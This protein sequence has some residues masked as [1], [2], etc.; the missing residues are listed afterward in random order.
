VALSSSISNTRMPVPFLA[1]SGSGRHA[2]AA[3]LDNALGQTESEL[4]RR[5]VDKTCFEPA[6]PRRGN[7][8]ESP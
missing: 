5:V 8:G 6:R 3:A 2:A 4:K 7:S 1:A